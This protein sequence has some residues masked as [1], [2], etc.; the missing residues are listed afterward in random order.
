[1]WRRHLSVMTAKLPVAVVRENVRLFYRGN[2]LVFSFMTQD[3]CEK[4]NTQQQRA[5]LPVLVFWFFFFFLVTRGGLPALFHKLV[6]EKKKEKKKTLSR[7]NINFPISCRWERAPRCAL[8]QARLPKS[9][10]TATSALWLAHGTTF[11]FC[12][13]GRRIFS[14]TRWWILPACHRNK[15]FQ[16]QLR[17]DNSE[18]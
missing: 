17:R 3:M 14:S 7:L 11:G 9:S 6:Q 5:T 1:M 4:T 13:N 15:L 10:M 16:K 2:T 12:P 18:W 8:N